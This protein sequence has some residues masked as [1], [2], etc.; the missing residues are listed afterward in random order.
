MARIIVNYKLIYLG[1][2]NSREEAFAL[3]VEAAKKYHGEFMCLEQR[4]KL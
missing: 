2:R 3:Y 1:K 4:R